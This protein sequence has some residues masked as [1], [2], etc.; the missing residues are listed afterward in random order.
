MVTKD[1]QIQFKDEIITF[2]INLKEIAYLLHDRIDRFKVSGN[3]G[4][5]YELY[6]DMFRDDCIEF[7]SDIIL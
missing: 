5:I 2:R 3:D 4:K 7:Y 6:T 1:Y